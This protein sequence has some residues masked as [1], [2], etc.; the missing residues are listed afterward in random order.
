M[1]LKHRSL[2]LSLKPQNTNNARD[3]FF[4]VSGQASSI[5]SLLCLNTT[6]P[7]ISPKTYIAK[8]C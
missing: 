4:S 5:C 3:T 2:L 7:V 6:P 1:D 8:V